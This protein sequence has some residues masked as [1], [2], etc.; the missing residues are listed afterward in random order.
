MDFIGVDHLEIELDAE[1]LLALRRDLLLQHLIGG[2]HEIG[3]AQPVDRGLL[4][5]SRSPARGKNRRDAAARRNRAGA[6]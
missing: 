2:R 3:R 1:R 4:G 5:I 6:G